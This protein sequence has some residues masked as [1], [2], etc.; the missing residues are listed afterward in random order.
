MVQ[1]SRY[2]LSESPLTTGDRHE[3][4]TNLVSVPGL[5]LARIDAIRR[6][7]NSLRDALSAVVRDQTQ[8]FDGWDFLPFLF[9]GEDR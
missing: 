6:L 1:T 3:A 4:S 8:P 9:S 7:T 2:L 5:A